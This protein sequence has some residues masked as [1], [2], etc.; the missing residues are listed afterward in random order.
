MLKQ[1]P[2]FLGPVFLK[3]KAFCKA[4]CLKTPIFRG[5]FF[6][7]NVKIAHSESTQYTL[8]MGV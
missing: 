7:E 1:Q 8:G 6:S 5:F 3:C 4:K 2:S